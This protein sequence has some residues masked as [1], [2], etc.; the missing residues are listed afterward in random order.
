M[1]KMDESNDLDLFLDAL[2]NM[3]EDILHAK[4]NGYVTEKGT[5]RKKMSETHFDKTIDLHGFNKREALV[6]L[7]NTLSSSKGK[8]HR[9]LVI[10]GKGNNSDEGYGVI[11]E[12]VSTYLD[13]AGPHYIREYKFASHKNGGD[14]AIEILTK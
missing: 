4:Y 10:T 12:A 13:K 7:R 8:R 3:P 6:V 5:E 11:R 2:N 1:K 9:I 14:G